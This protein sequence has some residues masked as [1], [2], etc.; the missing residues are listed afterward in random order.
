MRAKRKRHE[1]KRKEAK[2]GKPFVEVPDPDLGEEVTKPQKKVVGK[3]NKK[4][5][6]TTPKKYVR[7]KI[8]KVLLSES[9]ER[10]FHPTEGDDEDEEI[11]SAAK[12]AVQ[13]DTSDNNNDESIDSM[14][15]QLLK[16][17]K[18]EGRMGQKLVQCLRLK[19]DSLRRGNNFSTGN[20]VATRNNVVATSQTAVPRKVQ[21]ILFPATTMQL[22]RPQGHL[23]MRS[24]VCSGMR[25]WKFRR[26]RR[27][28][29]SGFQIFVKND[30]FRRIKF[31][32]SQ[33]SFAKAFQK[34]NEVERPK[35]PYVFQRF[36]IYFTCCRGAHD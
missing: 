31:V 6:L 5:K 29:R 14:E 30:L 13:D 11:K 3:S 21:R 34:V 12:E 4:E 33:Q 36:Q 35:H 23:G 2:R 28:W 16:S 20:D 19:K 22:Q 26:W 15:Q 32:N 27:M 10:S 7:P 17:N 24:G 8:A 9:E 1:A 25:N 18:K